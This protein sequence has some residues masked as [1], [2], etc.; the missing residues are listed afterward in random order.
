GSL[1]EAA[2][3]GML[4]LG[5]RDRPVAGKIDRLAIG[6][7]EILIVDYKTGRPP[8]P[9]SAPDPAHV[10]Q[11]ALYRALIASLYPGRIVRAA[12]LHVG[13][14]LMVEIDAD[15]MDATLRRIDAACR[16]S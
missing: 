2:V 9:G 13:A 8:L 12:L 5:G 4:C 14:P 3:Q 16:A 1:A 7:R 6:A 11:L 15:A 10:A